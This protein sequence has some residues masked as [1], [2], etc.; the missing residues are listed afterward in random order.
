MIYAPVS[1]FVVAWYWR[2]YIGGTNWEESGWQT[3]SEDTNHDRKTE[4]C[5][6]AS[7]AMFI[8]VLYRI[9]HSEKVGYGKELGEKLST[10]LS[11]G[12]DSIKRGINWRG[13][14]RGR[15]QHHWRVL[16]WRTGS[17]WQRPL[18]ALG[19]VNV[20]KKKGVSLALLWLTNAAPTCWMVIN[21]DLVKINSRRTCKSLE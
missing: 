13:S 12:R 11:Y 19:K 20:E 16:A 15:I 2:M 21:C 9:D 14:R 3:G 1:V 7:I 5:C 6:N 18:L 4:T 10:Y 8:L 17:R